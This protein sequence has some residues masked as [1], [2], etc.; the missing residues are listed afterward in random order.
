LGGDT[1]SSADLAYAYGKYSDIGEK[2]PEQGH[3]LHIWQT[4][5]AGAW[6]LVLDWQ[7]PLPNE[8]P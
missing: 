6:K 1:S 2:A 8:K 5:R 3:Y 7:Q 4:D